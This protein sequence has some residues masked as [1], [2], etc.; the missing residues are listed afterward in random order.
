KHLPGIMETYTGL[1][2]SVGGEQEDQGK[3]F[4]GLARSY[5][6]ALLAIFALLAIP[7]RS[8]LQPLIIMSVIPFGIVGAVAGHLI[9]RQTISFSSVMG[10]VALSG[11]VVNASLVLVDTV[12]RQRA[13][14]KSLRDAVEL[15]AAS[16]FRPIVLT[17][18][19]TFVG[20]TPLLLGRSVQAKVLLPMAT[21]MAF[22][23][24]FATGITLV[25]VP[26]S[27]III[28][29]LVRSWRRPR[30]ARPHAVESSSGSH[31]EA[32]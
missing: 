2:L 32:A 11:V 25:L 23:V 31:D 3:A 1:T 20:L 15:A 21:S 27:Y 17:A 30:G 26:C 8:Y 18:I 9:M 7:L 19:T 13:A 22:G 14:G 16:R 6:M 4:A 29:D 5:P 10:I 24:M 12:N 28:E